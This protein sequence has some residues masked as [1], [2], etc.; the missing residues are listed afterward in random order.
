MTVV[1]K[2]GWVAGAVFAVGF[3]F[4]SYYLFNTLRVPSAECRGLTANAGRS[5]RGF[6]G[7]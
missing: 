7:F 5:E 1:E 6:A 3:S 2:K 4:G